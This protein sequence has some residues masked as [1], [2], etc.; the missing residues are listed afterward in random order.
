MADVQKGTPTGETPPVVQVTGGAQTLGGDVV[1]IAAAREAGAMGQPYIRTQGGHGA[2]NL[3]TGLKHSDTARQVFSVPLSTQGDSGSLVGSAPGDI[4]QGSSGSA[5]AVN[6]YVPH[7]SS[8]SGMSVQSSVPS[9][10]S[11]AAYD[12]IPQEGNAG[13]VANV[14]N[15]ASQAASGLP[16]RVYSRVS[17]THSGSSVPNLQIKAGPATSVQGY[18]P[19]ASRLPGSAVNTDTP[20]VQSHTAVAPGIDCARTH[21]CSTREP[22]SK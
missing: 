16:V 11:L 6:G 18:V 19:Q 10:S 17:H 5:L 15:Y 22:I 20:N 14:S 13:S 1:S 9:E 7:F 8:A 12:Y 2:S 4:S 3:P 21:P